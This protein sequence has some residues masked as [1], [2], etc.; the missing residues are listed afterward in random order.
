M[1][2]RDSFWTVKNITGRLLV[3]LRWWSKIKPDGEQDWIFEC[4]LDESK[5]NS[6]DKTFFWGGQLIFTGV[7][8][9][10]FIINTLSL[11]LT[12]AFLNLFVFALLIVNL[13]AYYKCSD[14]KKKQMSDL[15]TRAGSQVAGQVIKSS[16]MQ[17]NRA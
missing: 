3:G 11:K 4:K 1:C 9:A 12:V 10:I 13:Y 16:L 2:I 15:A 8:L 14:E 6:V 7:W 5:L 17:G